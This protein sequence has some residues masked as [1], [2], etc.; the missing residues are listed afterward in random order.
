MMESELMRSGRRRV[1]G[2]LAMVLVL[3]CLPVAVAVA[4][5]PQRLSVKVGLA[6]VRAAPSRK[7]KVLWQVARYHPFMVIGCQGNWCHCRDFEGDTGWVHKKLLAR[8]PT[9]I[10]IK[11]SCNVR[12]GPGTGNRILFVVDREVPLKVLKR[13]GHWLKIQHEDGDQGWI[14]RSLVW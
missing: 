14:H 8:I 9:V 11:E 3:V 2:T 12:S 7:A 6:N 4:A 13:Q 10:T 1:G 5:A